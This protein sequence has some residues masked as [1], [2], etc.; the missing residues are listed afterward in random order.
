MHFVFD[1]AKSATPLA[2]FTPPSRNNKPAAPTNELVLPS[3]HS[4][5]HVDTLSLSILASAL[6]HTR[7]GGRRRTESTPAKVATLP[8][9]QHHSARSEGGRRGLKKAQSGSKSSPGVSLA[10]AIV[11][12]R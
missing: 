4:E 9:F 5:E 3:V 1:Q 6:L 8:P 2:P 12:A 10:L 11:V 7:V